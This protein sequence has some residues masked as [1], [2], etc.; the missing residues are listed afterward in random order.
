[1]ETK[2]FPS[3]DVEAEHSKSEQW[4]RT[5]YNLSKTSHGSS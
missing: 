1:M 5:E 4:K 3:T 2:A